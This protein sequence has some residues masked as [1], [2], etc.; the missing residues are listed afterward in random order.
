[1]IHIQDLPVELL[2]QILEYVADFEDAPLEREG[3]RARANWKDDPKDDL[4][5]NGKNDKDDGED[6]DGED[7]DFD[8]LKNLRNVC[9]VSRF[10]R[11]LAQPLLFRDFDEDGMSGDMSKIVS[12]ARA[13]YRNENLGKHVQCISIM[14]L[15]PEGLIDMN[16][17]DEDFSLFES[18]IRQ[19]QLPDEKERFWIRLMKKRD[20]SVFAALLLKKTPNLRELYLPGLELSLEP[21]NFL[22]NRNS[23]LLPNLELLW[24][25]A[26][27][28]A[29]GYEIDL[30]EKLLELPKLS[31]VTFEYG[32]L[33]YSSLPDSWTPGVLA[34]EHL[35]FHHCFVDYPALQKLSR[36]C[37]KLKAFAY[38]NFSL[39]PRERRSWNQKFAPEFNA[40]QAQ[41]ALLLH[42]DTLEHFNLAF[43]WHPWGIEELQEHMPNP[44]KIG[45]FRD[46]SVLESVFIAHDLLPP[47][48]QL[49]LSIKRFHI[50]NCNSSV[51]DMV[52]YIAKDCKNGLY[53]QFTEF[54]V[55]AA[56]VTRPI[57]LAGQVI[58][59][60]QTPSQCF[61]SLQNMF[62]GTKV[63]FQVCPYKIPEFGDDELHDSDFEDEDYE[64][65]IGAAGPESAQLAGLLHMIMQHALDD[66]E[67]VRNG[68]YAAS[69]DSWETE[70]ND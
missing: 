2:G 52:Q 26:T 9:L 18:V 14:N 46:F 54:L 32:D 39:D 64:E 50:T 25:H 19:F 22:F 12:F 55:L 20:L 3:Q 61:L 65:Y 44:A 58:P 15:V 4:E 38:D 8:Y 5:T 13:I 36:A 62:D 68:L 63:D 48:P 41:E 21:I 31:D 28:E 42:K 7:E 33:D 56:D 27:V 30:Y 53:P 16:L 43:S 66:T 10:F 11:D 34:T 35:L 60:G 67:S 23:L 69:D 17:D 6:E 49:P 40:T 57:K 24:I 51:R 1:M 70:S 45:S 37:K 47:H 29:A 59:P